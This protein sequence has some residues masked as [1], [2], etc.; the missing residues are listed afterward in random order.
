[1]IDTDELMQRMAACI[2][3][4]LEIID[5]DLDEDGVREEWTKDAE[6]LM[7][8]YGDFTRLGTLGRRAPLLTPVAGGRPKSPQSKQER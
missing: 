1:M 4:A 8:A 2:E 5:A 6:E 3:T 7:I